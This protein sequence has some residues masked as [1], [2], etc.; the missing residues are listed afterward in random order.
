[1]RTQNKK[2]FQRVLLTRA[3]VVVYLL[4]IVCRDK[5][6]DH[7]KRGTALVKKGEHDQA[8][9]CFDKAIKIKPRFAEAYCNRWASYDKKG[10]YDRA[11]SD[12]N[13]VI[14][15]NPWFTVAY[16]NRGNA[17]GA[18]GE[19][20]RA[21]LDYTK[22]IEIDPKYAMAYYNRVTVWVRSIFG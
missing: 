9:L 1:M 6:V 17:Y 11:I 19:Y 7:F 18:K 5:S 12:F 20:N 13:K 21:I 10:E 22:A 3:M 15:I 16:Y 8:I 4:F 2:I 14:E